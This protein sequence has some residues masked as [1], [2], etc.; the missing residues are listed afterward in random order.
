MAGAVSAN[1]V[2]AH[3]V[4]RAVLCVVFLSCLVAAPVAAAGAERVVSLAP[5]ITEIVF[6]LGAGDRLVGVSSHCDY[7]EAAKR[8]DRV[9]TFLQPN[10]EVILAKRSDLVLAVPSPENRSAV[11]SLREFGVT[12]RVVDP[13]SIADVFRTIEVV[14]KDLDVVEAG[15]RLLE[16]IRADL[17]VLDARVANLERR[18]VLMVVGRRPLIAVGAGTFQ[19]ELIQRARG[20]NIAADAGGSWPHLNMEHVLA[21]APEVIIDSGMSSSDASAGVTFWSP[22]TSIPAVK[23]G[24]V[25]GAG[26]FDLLRPGP[27]LAQS[28]ETVARFIHPEVFS[29]AP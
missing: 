19:H 23:G 6:A 26:R 12:V 8:I 24:R 22:Y 25:F 28:L 21:R 18:R 17:A 29:P 13:G 9:G 5:S 10:L 2:V 14:A 1:R 27:R 20:L 11:E 16:G 3:G 7:P 15:A 4:G